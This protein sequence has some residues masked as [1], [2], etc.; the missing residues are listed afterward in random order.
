M[1]RTRGSMLV[2]SPMPVSFGTLQDYVGVADGLSPSE[3]A[4]RFPGAYLVAMGVLAVEMHGEQDELR[5]F[6]MVSPFATP[7]HAPGSA[8]P[9]QGHV[10]TITGDATVTVGREASCDVMIPDPSVS[11]MH[12][13][14]AFTGGA[15]VVSDHA[16]R[17]GTS[18]NNRPVRGE[19]T[20]EDGDLITFG[21]YSFQYFRP[22]TFHSVLRILR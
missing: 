7:K 8:T 18:V 20:L 4:L 15:A 10:F 2:Y 19:R 21:R 12:A 11:S 14:I 3:F 5:T 9:L 13:S 1:T 6:E 16:S 22:A 17:N